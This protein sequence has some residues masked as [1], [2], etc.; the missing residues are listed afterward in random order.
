ME[1]VEGGGKG[2]DEGEEIRRPPAALA[3]SAPPLIGWQLP[4]APLARPLPFGAIYSCT[5]REE[6]GDAAKRLRRD[7]FWL[8]KSQLLSHL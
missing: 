5:S 3:D 7:R 4:S 6:R 1:M 2:D 8:D